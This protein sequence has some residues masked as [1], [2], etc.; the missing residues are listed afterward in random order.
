MDIFSGVLIT[1]TTV[2]TMKDCTGNG[3]IMAAIA[4]IDNYKVEPGLVQ[5]KYTNVCV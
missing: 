4:I 3:E 2:L 5:I 1:M